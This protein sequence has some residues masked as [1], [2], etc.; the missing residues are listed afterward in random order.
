MGNFKLSAIEIR[1]AHD[2]S[3]LLVP[4]DMNQQVQ[5]ARVGEEARFEIWDIF[6]VGPGNVYVA[7]G[8]WICIVN[9]ATEI[10]SGWKQGRIARVAGVTLILSVVHWYLD[11][12]IHRGHHD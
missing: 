4:P 6:P 7:T 10:L 2:L 11:L 12:P 8:I 9:G 1:P 3:D 5:L